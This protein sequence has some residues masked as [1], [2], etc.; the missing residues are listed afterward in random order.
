MRNYADMSGKELAALPDEEF[1][2][3]IWGDAGNAVVSAA[4]AVTPFG[5]NADAFLSHCTAC[6][7]N[8]GG[9]LL[10]G[11]RELFPAVWEAIP[12][13]MGAYAWPGICAAVKLCGVIM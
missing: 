3:A 12:D 2:V 9:M 10:S 6:G 7:G 1:L 11:L 8:W 5:G 4:K 13:D